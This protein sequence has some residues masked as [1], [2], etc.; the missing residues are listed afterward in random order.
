MAVLKDGVCT[1]PPSLPDGHHGSQ[2]AAHGHHHF[3]YGVII[4]VLG[5]LVV[6]SASVIALYLAYPSKFRWLHR[7][8]ETGLVM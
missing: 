1:P 6:V 4:G 5:L 7:R 8:G 2:A 3:A